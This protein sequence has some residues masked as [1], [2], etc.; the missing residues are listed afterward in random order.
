MKPLLLILLLLPAAVLGQTDQLVFYTGSPAA[1]DLT[2]E[3]FT[4]TAFEQVEVHLGI[5]HPS[6][7]CVSGFEALAS[8]DGTLVAPAWTIFGCGLVPECALPPFQVG[9]LECDPVGPDPV[10]PLGTLTFFVPS[11]ADPVLLYLGPV[12]GS[13]YFPDSPGYLSDLPYNAVP[14][15]TIQ[16]TDWDLPVFSVNVQTV[17]DEPA[18]WGG[19]KALYR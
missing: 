11:P 1:P 5:L 7:P 18:T 16:G 14:L 17:D 6:Q 9:F 3:V 15:T 4:S 19:V 8:H 13:T 10:Y 2:P 12:P